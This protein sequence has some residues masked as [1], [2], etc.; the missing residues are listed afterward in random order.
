MSSFSLEGSVAVVTGATGTLGSA[1]SEALVEA[2]AR[3]VLMARREEPLRR[4]A[5]RLGA[6][7][8]PG[9]VRDE[10]ALDGLLARVGRVDILVN[11]AGGNLPAA[12]QA[13]GGSL[14]DLEPAALREVVDLNLMGTLLPCRVLGAAM[15]RQG[16]GA[17]VNISSLTAALPLT[18]VAGYGAAKAAVENLTRYLAVDLGRASG[19]GVRVNAIAPGF[20]LGDQNRDLLLWPDGLPTERGAAII[21]RTPAGRFGGPEEVGGTVVWLC[22]AAAAFVSGV[23][24]PIDGGFSA[25][26]GI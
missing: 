11:C 15:V 10:A 12:T 1:I 5:E 18:R 6:E 22:S 3:V 4:L 7:V 14:L 13:P 26:W 23:V 9:D 17:I 21:Q 2:S 20:F 19:G 25:G 16:S 24:V 8:F